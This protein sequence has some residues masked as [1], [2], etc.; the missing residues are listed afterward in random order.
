M[1]IVT[2]SHSLSRC[3]I[4]LQE[5]P[6]WCLGL[7]KL[8]RQCSYKLASYAIIFQKISANRAQK[9]LEQT[10]TENFVT[11]T[12]RPYISGPLNNQ[13]K[14]LTIEQYMVQ[15]CNSDCKVATISVACIP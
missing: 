10:F 9:Y 1:F 14:F 15:I 5:G 4:R 13:F 3:A 2:L 11:F 6:L 8:G 12:S 7:D